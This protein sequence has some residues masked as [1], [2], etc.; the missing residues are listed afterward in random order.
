MF[1]FLFKITCTISHFN[2]FVCWFWLY[3][4]GTKFDICGLISVKITFEWH[5]QVFV[6]KKSLSDILFRKANKNTEEVNKSIGSQN[7][8]KILLIVMY[9]FE[10]PI[11]RIYNITTFLVFPQN[12]SFYSF[13]IPL[14]FEFDKFLNIWLLQCTS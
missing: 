14:L 9:E 4:L 7:Y 11:Q 6:T 10:N 5:R 1:T 3:R 12:L 13:L 8:R 2:F